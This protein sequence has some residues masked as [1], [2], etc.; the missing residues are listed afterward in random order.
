MDGSEILR[1]PWLNPLLTL[2]VSPVA[3]FLVAYLLV[4]AAARIVR[5]E[6][7]EQ[8]NRTSRAAQCVSAG[9]TSFGTGI[10]AGQRFLIVALIA[11][12]AADIPQGAP[13]LAAL[14]LTFALM[15]A[16]GCLNGD[17]GSGTCWATDWWPWTRCAAWSAPPPRPDCWWWDPW[18]RHFRCPPRSPPHQR[19]SVP[20]PT[21]ASPP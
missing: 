17:G 15:I 19:S 4:F 16:L 8:I 20:D 18:R 6:E 14:T 11:L 1:L 12:S 2:I 9:L 21:S 13:I 5:G 3:A 7:A 10:Q